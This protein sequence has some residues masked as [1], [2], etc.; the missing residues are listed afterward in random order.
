[1]LTACTGVDAETVAAGHD[2]YGSLKSAV[3][4][5]V[6]DELAPLQRR[7]AS[8]QEQP[9]AVDRVLADGAARAA[10]RAAAT[11]SRARSA[12]GLA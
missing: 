9:E 12:I 1:V 4:D 11:L 7:H 5:A 2:D 10:R 6:V 3:A 8:L